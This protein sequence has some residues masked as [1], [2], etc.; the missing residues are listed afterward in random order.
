VKAIKNEFSNMVAKGPDTTYL[1][2]VKKAWLEQHKVNIKDNG[3]WVEK[4][5]QYKLQGGN[6][7]RFVHYDKYVKMLTPKDVQDA[8]KMVLAGNELLAIQLPENVKNT[9]AEEPK[10]GF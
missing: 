10:K 7:D 8:A 3:I 4:L 1:N 2:K 5:L 6:P 9:A